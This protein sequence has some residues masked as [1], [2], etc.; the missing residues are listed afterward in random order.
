MPWVCMLLKNVDEERIKIEGE[1]KK[2]R[3]VIEEEKELRQEKSNFYSN[4][5]GH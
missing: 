3:R 1:F 2:L 4:A 5:H